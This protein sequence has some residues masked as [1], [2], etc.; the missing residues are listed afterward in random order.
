M[1]SVFMT[2]YGL[3][4]NIFG[5]V[6]MK[7]YLAK[8]K[9][10]VI[11]FTFFMLVCVCGICC[12]HNNYR[13]GQEMSDSIER[14]SWQYT[15]LLESIDQLKDAVSEDDNR[16]SFLNT[17][18]EA[19][20]DVMHTA[21]YFPLLDEI[22]DEWYRQFKNLHEEAVRGGDE[23]VRSIFADE[24]SFKEI[25]HLRDQ[26]NHVVDCFRE[27]RENYEQM[28]V[29]DRYFTSWKEEQKILNEKVRFS[30]LSE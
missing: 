23:H 29:W 24:E 12:V 27:F 4:L 21:D 19:L 3:N 11:F 26:L 6:R 8:K 16:Y 7:E 1:H 2:G 28:S 30:P 9:S 10:I 14:L 17:Y 20:F 18:Y 15:D 22:R 5:V 25:A 13:L